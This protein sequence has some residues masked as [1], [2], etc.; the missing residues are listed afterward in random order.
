MH[1]VNP[2]YYVGFSTATIVASGTP[3]VRSTIAL[4]T[5][6]RSFPAAQ[7]ITAG[8]IVQAL[9]E[10]GAFGAEAATAT[11]HATLLE[12]FFTILVVDLAFLR[13]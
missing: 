2:M 5:P 10:R 7:W 8:P 3:S 6:V 9:F 13:V 11:A 12:A 1:S 4:T